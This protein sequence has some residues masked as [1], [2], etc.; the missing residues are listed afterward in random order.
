MGDSGFCGDAGNCH[1]YGN[2]GE[3]GRWDF[4]AG[5]WESFFLKM[6]FCH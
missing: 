3:E 4:F 1:D 5:I 2:V 6:V